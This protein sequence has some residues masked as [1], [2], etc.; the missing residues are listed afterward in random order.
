M[1]RERDEDYEMDI[2]LVLAKIIGLYGFVVSISALLNYQRINYLVDDFLNNE[3][4]L[5]LSALLVL[6]AGLI[7]INIHNVIVYDYRLLITLFGWLSFFQGL[8]HLLVPDL[9]Y[10][11]TLRVINHK[12]IIIVGILL[13]L[14]ASLWLLKAGF[15]INLTWL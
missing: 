14:V 13:C 15:S 7:I 2:S 9:A 11:I 1:K 8:F 4:I 12:S 3:A 5:Y 6:S 10:A